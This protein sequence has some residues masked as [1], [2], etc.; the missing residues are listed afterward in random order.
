[1]FRLYVIL[2]LIL[3]CSCK[4]DP[5]PSLDQSELNG[6]WDLH[7]KAE[8]YPDNPIRILYTNGGYAT[9][10]LESSTYEM[11]YILPFD[12]TS[13]NGEII[14]YPLDTL[15]R[16]ESGNYYIHDEKFLGN[17]TSN[18]TYSWEGLLEFKPTSGEVWSADFHLYK[19]TY[20]ELLIEK[21][22]TVI[23]ETGILHVLFRK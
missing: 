1:M 5:D 3:I 13:F 20:R 23:G 7:L 22:E 10:I 15:Y 9:L 11:N 4:P 14:S 18:N 12:T 21:E 8:F 6:N 17:I 19:G 2:S 16:N